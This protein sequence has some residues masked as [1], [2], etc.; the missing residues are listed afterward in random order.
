MKDRSN[1]VDRRNRTRGRP[2][3]PNRV[4][5]W[6]R[7]GRAGEV[8]S[9]GALDGRSVHKTRP[10][11]RAQRARPTSPRGRGARRAEASGG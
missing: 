11:P 9:C 2:N 8:L 4:L 5:P 3:R 7:V 1:Q 6:G 10:A